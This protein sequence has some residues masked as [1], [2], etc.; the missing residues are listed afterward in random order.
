MKVTNMTS[1]N[2]N[3]VANQALT[4]DKVTRIGS[5]PSYN[6][7]SMSI[8]CHIE[9]KNKK[10]SITGV[11]G[12][13]RNGDALGSCGQINSIIQENLEDITPSQGWDKLKICQFINIWDQWHLNDM[14]AGSPR[15][16]AYLKLNPV[17]YEYP[18][19]HYK[20][21][22]EVL[23]K[24]GLNPDTEYLHNSKPY[25]YGHAWLFKEVPQD[26]IE[27]LNNLPETDKKPAWV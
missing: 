15:Q 22:C 2:G 8:Y 18:Q 25:S 6:N 27:W 4:I 16:E 7:R 14:I 9:F 19:S 1:P 20:V 3:K 5:R 10:L 26:V 17:S 11:E 23:K 12:P 13:L 21:A 24:A